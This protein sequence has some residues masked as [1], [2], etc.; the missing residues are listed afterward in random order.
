MFAGAGGFSEGFLQADCNEKIFDFLL[1]SDIN[2]N[3][4]LTHR[5][6]YNHQLGWVAEFVTQDITE[7]TFLDNLLKKIDGKIVD[8][9]CGGPPCQSFSLAGKEKK[10]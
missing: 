4:E 10:V 7:P 3:C 2:E 8:V 1:A 6:R 5:V 9:V